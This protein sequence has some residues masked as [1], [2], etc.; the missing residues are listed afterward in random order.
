[1]LAEIVFM[2]FEKM[3]PHPPTFS[4]GES[5]FIRDSHIFRPG[6]ARE[7]SVLESH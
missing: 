2:V 6:V 1:M 7:H 4:H 5:V 3:P